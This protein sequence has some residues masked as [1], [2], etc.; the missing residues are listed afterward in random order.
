MELTNSIVLQIVNVIFMLSIGFYAMQNLQWYNYSP[1]RVLTKHKKIHWHFIYFVIPLILFLSV[2]HYFYIYFI[3]HIVLLII[4]YIKLDKKF[5]W[6]SRS[7]RFF[8]IYTLLLLI[9]LFVL[10]NVNMGFYIYFLSFIFAF[11]IS[12]I[13]EILIIKQFRKMALSKLHSMPN[14]SIIAITASYG[15]TSIKNFLYHL[16][17]NKYRVYA[18]PR[19]VNTLNGIIKDINENLNYDC[20]IY[21]TEAGAREKGDIANISHFLNHQYAILGEIGDQH[22]EYFKNMQNIIDTKYELIQSARLKELFLFHENKDPDISINITKFPPPLKDV[23]SNLEYSRFKLK[24][25]GEFHEF[26]T[27]IL[28]EFNISNLSVALL[29]ASSFGI[30]IKSLQK[31]VKKMDYIPHRLEKLEVNGKIILDDSFNGNING[32]RE[33]IRLSS[34]YNK[35]RKIIVTPGLVENSEENNK[36]LA[37]LIDEVFDIAIITGDLNSHILS[38]NIHNPQKIVLKDK[39]SLQN[40]LSSFTQ[41]GDLIL[42]ANDAPSYI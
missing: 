7:R 16:L 2:N 25:N 23:E 19:S 20:E 21:I 39:T 29:V 5:V 12:Y 15:K 37:S 22:I 4:W 26:E 42:F 30:D 41:K 9:N 32:M 11:I 14:L 18:T 35:G 3:V 10:L 1:I 8:I 33:S 40:I 24:L 38:S 36:I 17:S 31:S 27:K 6:T 13:G 34:L 28:G